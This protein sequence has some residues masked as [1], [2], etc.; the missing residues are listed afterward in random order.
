ML[1]A[2]YSDATAKK[3]GGQSVGC[4]RKYGHVDVSRAISLNRVLREGGISERSAGSLRRNSRHVRQPRAFAVCD[5]QLRA[6]CMSQAG[7]D[8]T[9]VRD[10]LSRAARRIASCLR[11]PTGRADWSGPSSPVTSLSCR[12]PIPGLPIPYWLD[13]EARPRISPGP[14]TFIGSQG[15]DPC[16]LF[17]DPFVMVAQGSSDPAAHSKETWFSDF[18]RRDPARPRTCAR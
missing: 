9:P 3:V 8:R 10:P 18:V 14:S 6:R 15:I 17:F 5:H 4:E 12:I 13:D 11:K 2:R 1:R 7:D 16:E